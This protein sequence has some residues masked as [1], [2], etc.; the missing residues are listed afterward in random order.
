[1]VKLIYLSLVVAALSNIATGHLL[2]SSNPTAATKVTANT[3]TPS[4]TIALEARQLVPLLIPS[5]T[6]FV[7]MTPAGPREALQGARSD[8]H[9]RARAE[10]REGSDF[11]VGGAFHLP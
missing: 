1:M 6:T 4:P 11:Q 10:A 8:D 3:T 9:T 5:P 2:P 7:T